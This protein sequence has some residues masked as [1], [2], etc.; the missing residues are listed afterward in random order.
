MKQRY[1]K[2]TAL[3]VPSSKSYI[4]TA[5]LV[6]LACLLITFWSWKSAVNNLNNDIQDSLNIATNE[7]NQT[8]VNTV[9]IYSEVL[10]GSVGLFNASN[11]VTASELSAYIN[12]LSFPERYPGLQAIAYS[13]IVDKNS[14]VQYLETEVNDYTNQP[15]NLRP[16]TA[17]DNYVITRLIEPYNSRSAVAIGFD[18]YT[19][20]TRRKTMNQARDTGEPSITDRLNLIQ[21]NK[22]QPGFLIFVPVYKRGAPIDTVEQKRSAVI[23]YVGAGVRS[24]EL[25]DG[26]FSKTMTKD[27]ALRVFDGNNTDRK[28]LIY[29]SDT[30]NNL[31]Q[32]KNISSSTQEFKIGNNEWTIV[33]YVNNKFASETQRRQPREILIGGFIFSILFAAL[34]YIYM[35]NRARAITSEKNLEV[36]EVKDNLISLASHQLRTPATGVKQFIGM[37]ME[38]YVGDI[39]KDQRSMLEKAYLSNERQ[40]EIINQILHVTRADSGRIDLNKERTNVTEVIKTVLEEYKQTIK[41]RKQKIV[42]DVP[43]YPVYINADIQ[44]LS[45]AFDNLL[46]NASKYSH[47][48]TKI[49]VL[50]KRTKDSVIISVSDK[51]V[52]IKNND[53]HLLFQKFSRIHNELSVEAG[54]NGIGLYLCKEIVVLHGGY[55]EVDSEHGKGSSFSIILPRNEQ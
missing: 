39:N 6:F 32:Q 16:D 47:T 53:M 28:N 24:K 43:S 36:Q 14:I 55:I 22:Q 46:T 7:A 18:P 12:S 51:G 45:M 26:L 23:G 15:L 27:L 33:T 21:D 48:R 41:N 20:P 31:A 5:T 52:G 35:T 1:R 11:D 38:G 2:S 25:I 50:I 29:Q 13:E 54:G 42:L 34:L 37:V 8:L 19:E 9:D 10:R 3:V 49:N 17:R 44:Y 40:L 4:I 30:Y